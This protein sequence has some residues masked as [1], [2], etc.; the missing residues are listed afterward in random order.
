MSVCYYKGGVA[1]VPFSTNEGCV[2]PV[3]VCPY[4]GSMVSVP[5]SPNE[6]GMAS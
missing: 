5:V 3:S 1:T 6:G 2:A 4:E